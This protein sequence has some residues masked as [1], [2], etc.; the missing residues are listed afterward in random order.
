MAKFCNSMDSY[1]LNG[2]NM[3]SYTSV[4]V[5][6]NPTTKN[7]NDDLGL[8]ALDSQ[9]IGRRGKSSDGLKDTDL[10]YLYNDN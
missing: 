4:G 8:V 3:P 9:I 7:L 1:Q 10:E 6:I 5:S 2:K